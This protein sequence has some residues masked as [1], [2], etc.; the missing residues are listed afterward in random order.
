M[1]GILKRGVCS[2]LIERP[3]DF[4]VVLSRHATRTRSRSELIVY[5]TVAH[6]LCTREMRTTGVYHDFTNAG[7]LCLM[8]K[9]WCSMVLVFHRRSPLTLNSKRQ[10]CNQT[11][12]PRPRDAWPRMADTKTATFFSFL[13]PLSP[14]LTRLCPLL[15]RSRWDMQHLHSMQQSVFASH[16][17]T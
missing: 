1:A 3:D 6:T 8:V 13:L 9:E 4:Q 16:L 11:T 17:F 12:R 14:P 5:D 2:C 15:L 7:G 10:M